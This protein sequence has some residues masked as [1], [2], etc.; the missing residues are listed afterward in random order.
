[1]LTEIVKAGPQLI[2]FGT[3]Q[4]GASIALVRPTSGSYFVD[5]FHM[6]FEVVVGTER[7]FTIAGTTPMWS[8]MSLH[9]LPGSTVSSS[10]GVH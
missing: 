5:A 1:M 7:L 4:R 9:M 3:I 2:L 6:P 8:R 10:C